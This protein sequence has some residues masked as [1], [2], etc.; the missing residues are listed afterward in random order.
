[1]ANLDRRRLARI[2]SRSICRRHVL[3]PSEVEDPTMID[4]VRS[5]QILLHLASVAAV[6]CGVPSLQAQSNAVSSPP[7]SSADVPV[8]IPRYDVATFKPT[9]ASDGNLRFLFTPDG[10]SISGV[11]IQML[12]REGF[13]VEDDHI[14][15]APGW[16]TTKRYDVQAKVSPEDAP[17]LDKLKF[18]ERRSM[19]VPLLVERLNLKYH[20]ETR[21][22]A[23]YTLVVAKGGPKMKLSEVQPPPPDAKPQA[24]GAGPAPGDA[25]PPGPPQRRMLRMMERGHLEAEGSTTEMLARVL[26]DQVG[27]TVVDKTGLTA[28]YDYNLE[29]TPDNAAPAK[30][31]GADGGPPRNDNG[32]EAVGPSIFT[33]VQEQLGLKLESTKGMVDVIVIDHIDLPSE[34]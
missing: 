11:P 3:K 12:L 10:I 29:W 5:R 24:A 2:S 32:G 15:G 23:G 31:G 18:D 1:M 4:I 26:S 27:R 9:A 22:L 13:H 30:P 20:H 28:T 16:V 6:F 25:P 21:E 34:N 19:I 8:D 33:A 17:K 14:I 7:P